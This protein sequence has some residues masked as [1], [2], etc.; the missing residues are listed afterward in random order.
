MRCACESQTARPAFGTPDHSRHSRDRFI[1]QAVRVIA[2]ADVDAA[3]APQPGK[4]AKK[5]NPFRK[6]HLGRGGS[7]TVELVV[8]PSTSP[9]AATVRPAAKELRWM[10]GC[11]GMRSPPPGYVCPACVHVHGGHDV[12]KRP[13]AG[14]A[15]FLAEC[16]GYERWRAN[17]KQ[18]NRLVAKGKAEEDGFGWLF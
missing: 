13:A 9:A 5:A 4:T 11:F 18:R 8:L 17:R 10:Q 1:A 7:R 15:H 6:Q 3:T 12:A 2:A 16:A 14:P